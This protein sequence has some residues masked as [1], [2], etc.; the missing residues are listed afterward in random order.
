MRYGRALLQR[1]K[2]C[3]MSSVKEMMEKINSKI[4]VLSHL[5]EDL[6]AKW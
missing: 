1:W 3:W 2:G 6:N 4:T 5:E